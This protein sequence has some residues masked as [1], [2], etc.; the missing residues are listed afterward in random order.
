M[1]LR[2]AVVASQPPGLGGGE[3]GQ[4]SMASTKASWTALARPTSPILAAS[5]AV[6]R[7][8]SAR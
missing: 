8:A 4:C 3:P 7:A 2:R 5:A 6:I 1:A